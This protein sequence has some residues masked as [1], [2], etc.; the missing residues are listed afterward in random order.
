MAPSLLSCFSVAS[1]S[2]F[3]LAIVSILCC[4]PFTCLLLATPLLKAKAEALENQIQ[5]TTKTL[6][7]F[8]AQLKLS[9]R[10]KRDDQ[11]VKITITGR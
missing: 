3:T 9:M 10:G 5:N 8:E 2:W 1:M 4:G 6:H 7:Q 11:L